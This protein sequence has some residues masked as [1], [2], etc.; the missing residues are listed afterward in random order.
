[1]KLPQVIYNAVILTLTGGLLALHVNAQVR[2]PV[3]QPNP[4]IGDVW[5]YESK[6]SSNGTE[7]LIT[8][9]EQL[10]D[11]ANKRRTINYQSSLVANYSRNYFQSLDNNQCKLKANS[12]NSDCFGVFKF[13]TRVGDK[14]DYKHEL[15][16]PMTSVMVDGRCEV[17]T[18]EKLTVIAGEFDTVR[19][20]CAGEWKPRNPTVT[21]NSEMMILDRR[22]M[23]VIWYA[24]KANQFVKRTMKDFG[25]DGSLNFQVQTELT[26]YT[27]K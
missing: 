10:L 27:T 16:V 17:V 7:Q 26:E 9:K 6:T 4:K 12:N 11:V 15:P 5:I 19:I 14:Y 3:S 13:P 8:Y 22:W 25:H 23:E 1:M 20:E 18:R 21:P 2:L 24:P